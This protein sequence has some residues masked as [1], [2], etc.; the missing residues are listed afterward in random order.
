[1]KEIAVKEAVTCKAGQEIPVRLDSGRILAVVQEDTG[2]KFAQ[3]DRVRMLESGG[4]ARIT[5]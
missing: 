3:G 1:M 2:E 4:Q 5:H